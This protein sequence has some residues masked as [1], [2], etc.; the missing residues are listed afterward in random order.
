[1]PLVNNENNQYINQQNQGISAPFT[2]NNCGYAQNFNNNPMM[3]FEVQSPQNQNYLNSS[4]ND[5]AQF[6]LCRFLTII[7]STCFGC[8]ILFYVVIIIIFAITKPFEG[9]GD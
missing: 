4:L 9:W 8:C 3:N 6:R 2:N 7:F 1:M 5:N